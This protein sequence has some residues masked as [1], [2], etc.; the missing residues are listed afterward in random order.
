MEWILSSGSQTFLLHGTL[1]LNLNLIEK[2][3]HVSY[4]LMCRNTQFENLWLRA[5]NSHSQIDWIIILLL[6]SFL[7]VQLKLY[8]KDGTKSHCFIGF[9]SLFS[10]YK[11]ILILGK[12][13]SEITKKIESLS[14]FE[15]FFSLNERN[16]L[17]ENGINLKPHILFPLNLIHEIFAMYYEDPDPWF[18]LNYCDNNN[19][20][21]DLSVIFMSLNFERILWWFIQI[22][23]RVT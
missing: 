9:N 12:N 21:T 7:A 16:W 11:I 6:F 15:T 1:D 2:V 8:E 18:S 5:R 20:F 4:T 19:I 13:W 23:T 3:S 14:K 10:I 17:G 22:V